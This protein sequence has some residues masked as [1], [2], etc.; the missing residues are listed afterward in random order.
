MYK[1]EDYYP[2]VSGCVDGNLT[3]ER[4]MTTTEPCWGHGD[5]VT[6]T[7]GTVSLVCLLANWAHINYSTCVSYLIILHRLLDVAGCP[8]RFDCGRNNQNMLGIFTTR[9]TSIR[10]QHKVISISLPTHTDIGGGLTAILDFGAPINLLATPPADPQE[11]IT[12][13]TQQTEN[14]SE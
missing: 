2:A 9:S 6:E 13:L 8:P 14:N 4:N 5:C 7:P 3:D 10:T 1:D 12:L 11:P